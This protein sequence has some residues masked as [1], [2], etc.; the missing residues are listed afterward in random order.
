MFNREALTL[1]G[2][3]LADG[4]GDVVNLIVDDVLLPLV[5]DRNLLELAVADDDRV[6][7]AGGDAGAELLAPGGLEVAL[8]R[9]Q[10]VRRRI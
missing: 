6:P 8:G 9:D 1:A 2:L 4:K 3:D 10:D 7:A 5:A